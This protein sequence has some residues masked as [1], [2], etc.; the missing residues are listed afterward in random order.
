M[1]SDTSH[2]FETLNL[3]YTTSEESGT[4]GKRRRRTMEVTEVERRPNMKN[5]KMIDDLQISIHETEE[6]LPVN[7]Q[8][9][10]YIDII[11][12]LSH[13]YLLP[14]LPIWVDY[15]CLISLIG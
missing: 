13:A 7:L 8:L 6:T 15:N 3:P 9:Y 5:P 2:E 14:N 4:V 10:K 12:M 1:D 11:W